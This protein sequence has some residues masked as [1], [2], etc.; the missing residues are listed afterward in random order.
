VDQ[1]GLRR[2]AGTTGPRCRFGI[3]RPEEGND[4]TSRATDFYR[5]K[6]KECQDIAGSV[7]TPL[8]KDRWMLLA[9]EWLRIA[10]EVDERTKNSGT[11]KG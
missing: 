9:T 5:A 2:L 3:T 4:M 8:E 7:P 1:D 10:D 6:A 11:G